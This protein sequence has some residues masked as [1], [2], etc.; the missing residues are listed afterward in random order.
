MI[1][2]LKVTS[3]I[4]VAVILRVHFSIPLVLLSAAI[5]FA[6]WGQRGRQR[7][8]H[9]N[10]TQDIDHN[11][12]NSDKHWI[13]KFHGFSVHNFPRF[14]ID[15]IACSSCHCNRLVHLENQCPQKSKEKLQRRHKTQQIIVVVQEGSRL[16]DEHHVKERYT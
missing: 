9:Q 11:Q 3:P 8:H 10:Q 7:N 15:L 5:L 13:K 12:K 4:I 6:Q 1:K 2:K 14:F 16:E